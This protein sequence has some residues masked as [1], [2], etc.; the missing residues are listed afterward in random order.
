MELLVK[1]LRQITLESAERQLLKILQSTEPW[2]ASV[3]V[4]DRLAH[5]YCVHQASKTDYL[6]C[7][8]SMVGKIAEKASA[9]IQRAFRCYLQLSAAANSDACNADVTDKSNGKIWGWSSGKDDGDLEL[10]HH[11]LRACSRTLLHRMHR[12]LHAGTSVKWRGTAAAQ[13]WR[14]FDS[15]CCSMLFKS[16]ACC[17]QIGHEYFACG[18]S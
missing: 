5:Y 18:Q 17:L 16:G 1:I 8:R 13:A 12:A 15:W 3:V 2:E 6:W 10:F 14:A 9:R 4:P 7:L 11:E